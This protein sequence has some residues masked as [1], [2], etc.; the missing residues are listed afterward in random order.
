MDRVM[1]PSPARVAEMLNKLAEAI[2]AIQKQ[3]CRLERKVEVF[4]RV[5]RQ[6]AV[7]AGHWPGV[8]RLAALEKG[9]FD[10]V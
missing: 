1:E 5:V 6:L 7:L 8:V 2:E 4:H 9:E 3:N 10:V